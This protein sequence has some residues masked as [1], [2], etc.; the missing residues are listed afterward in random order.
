M[1]VRNN[2]AVTLDE[3]VCPGT[4]YTKAKAVEMT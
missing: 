3:A 1:V 2:T 4:G